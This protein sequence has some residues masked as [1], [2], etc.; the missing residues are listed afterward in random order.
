MLTKPLKSF[1]E[2]IKF[3]DG[4]KISVEYKFDG[5]RTHIQYSR[6]NGIMMY[7]RQGKNQ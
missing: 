5:E 2:A 1:D 6:S 3:I 7:S 4:E